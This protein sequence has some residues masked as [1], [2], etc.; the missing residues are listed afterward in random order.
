[1]GTK[2]V[3]MGTRSQAESQPLSVY[4]APFKNKSVPQPY[5]DYKI[6]VKWFI[7]LF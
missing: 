3:L 7:S 2:I 5:T 6:P 1:M 4:L